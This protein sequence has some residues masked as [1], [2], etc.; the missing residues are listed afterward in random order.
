MELIV[1]PKDSLAPI[2]VAIK[3]AT[4]QIDVTIF[5]FDL[6]ELQRALE[7]AV[8]R[9]VK[10]HALIA[11]TTGKGGK[12][13]RKLELDL[14]AAGVTVSRTDDDLVRYHNKMVLIDREVLYTLGFNFTRLD[15][16]HSRSMGVATKNPRAVAEAVKLF[17]ADSTRQPYTATCDFFLVSPENAR[18][19]LAKL[20]KSATKELLIY[21]MKVG[22]R[23]MIKLLQDRVK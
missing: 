18:T 20:I 22:D 6:K 23:Q 13:L 14:L 2:I 4:K 7:S 3:K 21:D 9:G 16:D 15:T 19:G 5:R 10:V 12:G 1:Q 8:T 11:H 17:E